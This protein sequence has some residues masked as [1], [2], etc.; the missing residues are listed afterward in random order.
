M[1]RSQ[2]I[3]KYL[4]ENR[5]Y[6]IQ[7]DLITEDLA[8]STDIS[9][10]VPAYNEQLCLPRLLLALN[11]QTYKNFEVIIVDNGSTDKTKEVVNL[12]LSKV[13]Y[14]LYLVTESNKGAANAR[15]RGMD[16][17]LFR[18][19]KR[20]N[21]FPF[22]LIITTDADTV[23]PQN[24][25]EKIRLKSE[26]SKSLAL[27]GTHQAAPEVELTIEHRLGIKNYFNLIPSIIELFSKNN[28]GVKS[29]SLQ[30]SL[31]GVSRQAR[32]IKMSGPNSAFEIEAYA[33]GGGMK[34]E[35]DKV[36][37]SVKLNE[38]NSLGKR[39]KQC[40]YPVIPMDVRVITS[41]R[42]Q[43]R[44]ILDGGNS[45]F[46]T[47][48]LEKDRF[49]VVRED[50]YELLKFALERIDKDNWLKYRRKIITIV[51]NNL[52]TSSIVASGTIPDSSKLNFQINKLAVYFTKVETLISR[53]LQTLITKQFAQT[54]L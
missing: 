15:K 3:K 29:V 28:I 14:P 20:N 6:L 10:V 4:K 18:V 41:K 39:I 7:R 17:A 40:G 33:A 30:A 46:P 42:R 19:A 51:L 25:L 13:S 49:N 52:I 35:Y 38:A 8:L 47:G 44:E 36:T 22:H 34:Q 5:L 24:W 27:A 16:E 37:G 23:P 1:K 11:N 48:Y 26:N 32:L 2:I 54:T 12:W 43:L 50:E 21:N 31:N 9:I 53:D 45:Y